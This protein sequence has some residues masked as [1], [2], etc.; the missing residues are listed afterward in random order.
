MEFGEDEELRNFELRRAEVEDSRA[1]GDLLN[2]QG[3]QSLFRATFGQFNYANLIEYSYLSLFCI[4]G[5]NEG[6]GFAAFNDVNSAT[7]EF[8]KTIELLSRIVA[9]NVTNTIFLSFLVAD[10][11]AVPGVDPSL[12]MVTKAF[13]IFPEIDFVAWLCPTTAK[14]FPYMQHLFTEVDDTKIQSVGASFKGYK[15]FLAHRSKF[16][17]KLLVREAV[18]EDN[19]D[20]LPIIQ[21]CNPNVTSGQ[22]EFY[23]AQ[24]IQSQSDRNKIFVGVDR[25]RPVGMLS[26]SL[27]VNVE[28]IRNMYD[29]NNYSDL[30]TETVIET[31]PQQVTIL[32]CGN[33]ALIDDSALYNTAVDI[34][35]GYIDADADADF[36]PDDEDHAIVQDNLVT[37]EQLL[38]KTIGEGD[39]AQSCIISRFPR[40]KA[41]AE[42]F[43]K[44]GFQV[45]MIV[46]I[47]GGDLG[48]IED[49]SL[50]NHLA[51]VEVLKNQFTGERNLGEHL[52]ETQCENIMGGTLSEIEIAIS[53]ENHVKDVIRIREQE[54]NEAKAKG[55]EGPIASAFAVTAFAIT[56][57]FQS[58]SEDLLRVAFEEHPDLHYCM[59]MLPNTATQSA[60]CRFM[61]Y[62]SLKPGASFDQSLYI[63]HRDAMLA[64]EFL[65]VRRYV[66]SFSEA[67]QEFVQPMGELGDEILDL[68]KSALKDNA[69][70]LLDNPSEVCF[71]VTIANDLIGVISL[72]RKIVTSEDTDFLRANF[73]VDGFI[74]YERHRSRS[75][76]AITNFALSPIFSKWSKFILRE[77]MRYYGKTL[78]YYQCQNK[79]GIPQDLVSNMVPV[80]PRRRMQLQ[81]GEESENNYINRPTSH[82]PGR[83]DPL[84][85]TM[86][87][88]LSDP[89]VT[90]PTRIVVVGGDQCSYSILETLCFIPYLHLLNIYYVV[91]G[92]PG[93]WHGSVCDTPLKRSSPNLFPTDADEPLEHEINAL[94]LRG[95]VTLV[96][97]R[98]TDID[99]K[100]KVIIV[101]DSIPLEYDVLI[102]SAP[103]Q[104]STFRSFESTSAVHPRQLQDVGVFSLGDEV[105]NLAVTDW[106]FGSKGPRTPGVVVYGS[107]VRAW[108]VVGSMLSR[109][110]EAERIVWILPRVEF[111]NGELGHETID[112]MA[113]NALSKSGVKILVGFELMDVTFSESRYVYSVNIV[114]MPGS[115][116]FEKYEERKRRDNERTERKAKLAA[117]R[118]EEFWN[119]ADVV[120]ERLCFDET[121][122]CGTL[123]M[124]EKFHANIDVFSAINDSGLVYDG[125]IVVNSNF[126]TVDPFIFAAGES[127]RFSRV[128][129]NAIQHSSLNCRELGAFVA[130]KVIEAHLDPQIAGIGTN[131]QKMTVTGVISPTDD[132]GLSSSMLGADA[133]LPVFSLPRSDMAKLPGDL[134]FFRSRLPNL[135]K[136]E[137]V[138]MV[139]GGP[140]TG[141]ICVVKTDTFGTVVEINYLGLSCVEGRNIGRLVGWHES[142]LS[143][144]SFA[145]E[146]GQISDWLEYFREPWASFIYH[147]N[148]TSFVDALR[149]SLLRDKGMFLV[150]DSIMELAQTCKDD[151]ILSLERRKIV[152]NRGENIPDTAK[153]T[154]EAHTLDFL[155]KNKSAF[156]K[157]FIPPVGGVKLP[158]AGSTHIHLSEE[159]GLLRK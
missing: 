26:T 13:E 9:C 101:S 132:H 71:V 98:L 156:T 125:G 145:F 62:V 129:S 90:L 37:L 158:G 79:S 111:E 113:Q 84:Y 49:E 28:F 136:G 44:S 38:N 142:F 29:L 96:N 7:G 141:R 155:R 89:R 24:L 137:L 42:L 133:H 19:D 149:Q 152:G 122:L 108:S 27:D 58:R 150:Q 52:L 80:G 81:S 36:D 88:L 32:V 34:K 76:A 2:A 102:I 56:D 51:G 120:H 55:F 8:D 46:F 73:Q 91:D 11:K 151:G 35:C 86:K 10:T 61:N 109:G 106:L 116:N 5:E 30:I 97:G 4:Y 140:E 118:S 99:R 72:S 139:T 68:A 21:A 104:D 31:K 95:R 107:G 63:I 124:C 12:E 23:L 3:G 115:P 131:R 105:S 1:F 126:C 74:N 100:S 59:L 75:Q 39:N 43:L 57:R 25:N 119:V 47:E 78:L 146:T 87:R 50:K 143:N 83:G 60:L 114:C 70:D 85:F 66:P 16:M 54:I 67:L 69:V 123:L 153:R 135:P 154:T 6:V 147:D 148:F 128:H 20:L 22:D 110:L 82:A 93:N 53:V 117:E 112:E 33:I 18:I 15:V 77:V 14:L 159:S 40:S 94:G 65:S 92:T 48:D 138:S 17:P 103:S 130:L 144:A 45:D 157:I 127:S 64:N 134:Y 41:E 121:V